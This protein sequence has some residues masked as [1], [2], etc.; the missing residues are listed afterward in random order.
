MNNL[1]VFLKFVYN[2]D[3]I[4]TLIITVFCFAVLALIVFD[5]DENNE[6]ENVKKENEI[7]KKENE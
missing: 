7:E 3:F 1:I 5:K 2:D 4:M 6:D